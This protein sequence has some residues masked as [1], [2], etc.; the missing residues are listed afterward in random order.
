MNG[1]LIK[2]RKYLFILRFMPETKVYLEYKVRPAK[3]YS[4]TSF[5]HNIL[6]YNNIILININFDI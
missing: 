4:R 5:K 6:L 2:T 1:S 3:N